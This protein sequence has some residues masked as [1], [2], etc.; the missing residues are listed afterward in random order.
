MSRLV[1]STTCCAMI[2]FL[3]AS[4]LAGDKAK[5]KK[6]KKAKA[7][8]V[9]AAFKLSDGITLTADQQAKL[10][11]MK[12]QYATKLADAQKKISDVYTEEQRARQT[13]ARR[14]AMTAGKKGKELKA[15]VD[16]AVELTDE[17]QKKLADAQKE[18]K[19][20]TKE[21]RKQVTA[22]LSDEQ[23]QKLKAKKS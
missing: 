21:V 10:D 8:A 7:A 19:Q 3:A 22:L 14:D 23:K 11:D 17:Q 15:A 1:R 4:I 2:L 6:G 16:A 5:P 12:T 18:Q 13:T 20:L 9:P